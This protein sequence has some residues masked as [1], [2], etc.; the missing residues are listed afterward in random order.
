MT[1]R[2][3]LHRTRLV[4][5]AGIVARALAWGAAAA[6]AVLALVA[7]VDLLVALPRPVRASVVPLAAAAGAFVL[8]ALLWR[9]RHVRSPARVALWLEERVPALDWMLVAAVDAPGTSAAALESR[10]ESRLAGVTWEDRARRDALRALLPALAALGVAVL[11]LALLPSGAVARVRAPRAGDALLRE[12]LR[13]AEPANRLATIVATVVAPA[14][15]GVPTRTLDDPASVTGLVGGSV[16]VEGRGSAAG[17]TAQVEERALAV[18][19]SGARWTV[20]LTMPSRPAAL[21][22]S[23]GVRERLVV[24]EPRADAAPIVTLLAPVRDSVL[25]EPRGRLPLR[26]QLSDDL[27]LVS[28]AFEAIVSSGEGES[29]TF[30]ATT[31][32]ARRLGGA[33][34]DSLEAWLPLDSLALQPG[35]IVHLRAVARDANDV[36]GPGIGSSET[37]TLRIPRPGEYDSLAIEGAPPP[38]VQQGALSQ[39]MLILLAEALEEKRPR[40]PREQTVSESRSIAREQAALRR[41]VGDIVFQRLGGESSAEHSHEGEEEGAHAEHDGPLSPEEILRA[42]DEA[43]GR[44]EEGALDFEHDET[45][46]VAINR[47]LLEAYNAMWDAGRELDVGE[48][49]AALPH[50]RRALAWI[51]RARAAER[52]YLRGR[53]PVAVVDIAKV[54]LTGKESGDPAPRRAREADD[55]AARRLERLVRALDVLARDTAAGTD[56]LILLRVHALGAD[57]SLAAALGAAVD[58]LRAGRDATAALTRVRRAAAGATRASAALGAWSGAW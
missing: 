30:R 33:R 10:L 32:G 44:G 20:R 25:R 5:A 6:I 48:P 2:E 11:V 58:A 7:G 40:I 43:T 23:D 31:I 53:P 34:R 15:S 41:R 16:R 47:P 12:S 39:R 19:E 4:L 54:R 52:I 27:G 28:A 18:G 42:A 3:R 1:S 46:V 45:P 21:R 22:L 55:P 14:Y 36:T 13:G 26:A 29:Y 57:A 51:Q 49:G 8:A 9:G 37:R 17:L 24:L 56:S 35:D 50:M 38:D